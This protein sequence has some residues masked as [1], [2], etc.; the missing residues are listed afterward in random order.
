MNKR[1][2]DARRL[3][4]DTIAELD[5][6]KDKK[7]HANRTVQAVENLLDVNM[8]DA[9]SYFYRLGDTAGSIYDALRTAFDDRVWLLKEAQTYMENALEGINTKDW[10][11]DNAKVHTFMIRGK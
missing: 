6:K 10:T 7:L 1:T 5:Q 9:R 11:G 3:G 4:A 2:N 8:M